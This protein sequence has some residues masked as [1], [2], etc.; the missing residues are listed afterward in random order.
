ML[1][2]RLPEGTELRSCARIDNRVYSNEPGYRSAL[3]SE[4]RQHIA[5]QIVQTKVKETKHDYHTEIQVDVV[6]LTHDQLARLIQEEALRLDRYMRPL[7]VK[8]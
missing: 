5:H 4:I 2:Y 1:H 8:P 6:V 3:L 7:K